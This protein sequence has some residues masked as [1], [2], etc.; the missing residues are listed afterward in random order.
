MYGTLQ[1]DY[2]TLHYI[3]LL[4]FYDEETKRFVRSVMWLVDLDSTAV[5]LLIKGH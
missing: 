4:R 3:A 1:I 5:R 2:F